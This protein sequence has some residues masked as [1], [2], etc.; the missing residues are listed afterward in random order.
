MP[1]LFKRVRFLT[2]HS[3]RRMIDF[4][5]VRINDKGFAQQLRQ[6]PNFDFYGKINTDTGEEQ[7]GKLTAE[8]KNLTV[9]L[10]PSNLVEITGSLHK[11]ANGGAHNYD[12]FSFGRLVETIGE[13]TAL[14]NTSPD[15]VSLH[16][17]EFG[18]NIVLDTSPSWFLDNVLNYRFKLPDMRTFGGNGYLKQWVQ[19]NY[20]V[21]VYD[22]KHQYRLDTNVLRFEVKTMAM[23]HLAGV[24][25]RTLADL[26]DGAKLRRLG[27]LLCEKGFND[28]R[29]VEHGANVAY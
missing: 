23:V 8:L 10:Y 18:V 14:L 21:K 29:K 25:V 17:V 22:K 19:Q 27:V 26:M 9:K 3:D 4:V 5:K 11:F 16:N 2:N 15:R 20:I 6:N 7:D 1:F 12:A 24:E 13:V 28:G